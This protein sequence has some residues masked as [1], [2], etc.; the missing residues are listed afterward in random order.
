MILVY[1]VCKDRDEARKIGRQ[2]LEK[3]LA[4]CFNLFPIESMYWWEGKL[5]EDK[6]VVLLAKTVADNYSAVTKEV[7]ALHSYE[8]PCIMS[9]KVD[10][11]EPRYLEWLQGEV[12]I[13]SR[14]PRA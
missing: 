12:Q 10:Q 5:T 4:A 1:I 2:L 9:V 13:A 8:V 7:L 6:E 14:L 11:V 3:R